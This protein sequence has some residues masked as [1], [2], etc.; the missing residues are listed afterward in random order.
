[1][2]TMALAAA[3]LA[4]SAGWRWGADLAGAFDL[5]RAQGRGGLPGGA[6][7][8]GRR[9]AGPEPRR[10]DGHARHGHHQPAAGGAGWA[11][12]ASER[13]QR[14]R[15]RGGHGGRPQRRRADECRRRR[16]S[17]C[18]HLCGQGEEA[19]HAQR[20]R[21]GAHRGDA[22]AFRLAG[23]PRRSGQLGAGLGHAA[24]GRPAGHRAGR[25]LGL[26]RGAEAV[27]DQDLQG[28]AG[29]GRGLCRGR[30]PGQRAHR[31]RLAPAQG[32]ARPSAA[33]R[34]STRT[35]SPSGIRAASR[36]RPARCSGTPLSPR[37]C[38]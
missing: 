33:A 3:V 18:D 21:H 37:P 17:L 36:R 31:P 4:A 27:R 23:L 30:L 16:R 35:R 26:G 5:R 6:R 34:P 38:A 22:G 13:R 12:G 14:H 20:Q 9:L 28:G 19:L 7:Q 24:G 1:M 10:G 32:P 15:R 8:P 11:S 2:K 25:G 29:A